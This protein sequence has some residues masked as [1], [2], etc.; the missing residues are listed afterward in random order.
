MPVHQRSLVDATTSRYYTRWTQ[1]DAARPALVLAAA[2]QPMDRA[3][4]QQRLQADLDAGLALPAA[5]RRLRNLII[6]ALITRDLDGRADLAEV[7]ATMTG[8]ADFAVQT[9]LAA[10]MQEQTALYGQPIGE[11]SGRPQEMIVLGMGKLGGGELNVSSDIDLIFVY[12]EDGDTR[13]EAGQKSLSNHEFFVRLGKKLIGA[14]A[15]ITEDGFTF[16]VDMALRPNGNSGPLVASFNM[17]EEY[18]VRQGR[19]WERYAWTKARAL[20]GTPED[21]A[22]LEAISRP[23]I[24][25]RYLDF[26]SIDALRSMHG[27]IR[28]EVKRQEALHPDRSNNVKLGR[29]GIREIEFTSQVFQ[30]IRGGRDV[31]LRDRSTR[32]T[33][34]TL[35]AKELLAPEVV[36]Q[37]LDAYSFLRDLEH[38]LQYL[39]DAQT[40]TLPVNPDDLLLVA[41]MMGYPDSAALLHELEGQRAIVAAQFDAIFADKQSGESEADGPAVSVSENDNLEGL[42]DALRLVGFPEDDVEDG[43]RRLHLT[44]Q[45]PRMQS[46]PEAS[47]NRLNTVIN[48]CLPLLA[49]LHYDELPALGRLLDFL[50]AI[51]R[52]AAYLALLTEY[53]YAL[54][55]LV[56]MIGASGWAATYL[57]RHP[58][59]LD[60]LLDDRNLKAASDWAAFSDNCRRQLATAEGDTERQLDILRELHHA[61][62]FRLLAQ[63]L[64]GDLS[65]EKLADEL[66]AL[67]DVLVQV[68]IEAV[69]G[70]ITQRHREVPQFAVIAYGKLGGKELGYA[71]DL[72][73]VFLYDDDDQEAPALYAKLAQRFITWMTSHTPAG[74]LFDIDIALRPDGASGLLV[75]PLSAFEKYQLNAAWI[76]EHQALTRARF[77][78]GDSAIGERFE[79]LRERVLRQP[80]DADK[81][82]EEVLSMRRRM[83]DAHPNRSM[84]FDLKHDEGGMI[85]IEFMVQYLVLRHACDHP[86]L[87]GDIGNIALLKLAAQLGLIDALMADEAANAYRLFRKLQHQIRLQGSDRAHIDAIRVEH[88]RAC[89]IRLWQQVFG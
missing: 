10:L 6:C 55:R 76:W 32:I 43:A 36:Q 17:V 27:Q 47:R 44:W 57:T 82:E 52:R 29:G 60:E 72:D 45:S 41:Q 13:A 78:A 61:E 46:L 53:P 26:G 30:L 83:R 73:V 81:L 21:I 86:Q 33:L 65:V 12:P 18:L 22:T 51:A 23:F 87:T 8:F 62:Q 34:R 2:A 14:L 64:E 63:D 38:R 58:L 42:A 48:N 1:A 35:A 5:M 70:T 89:V 68:T 39:E 4:M 66:S 79:A 11:E 54:Q 77:C 75:S 71:S 3:G 16:R 74:T 19:E 84:M 59:L 28:A 85:D 7:V 24:F 25:R 69:W 67:A 37:L 40:H 9:H 49:A 20:T 50:E 31:E 56:R 80:R 88:E 15:E